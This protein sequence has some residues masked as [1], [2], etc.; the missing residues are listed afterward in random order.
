[1][2]LYKIETRKVPSEYGGKVVW[3]PLAE[4]TN[5]DEAIEYTV[6]KK[7]TGKNEPFAFRCREHCLETGKSKGVPIQE[8][9]KR[10][11]HIS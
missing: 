2:K 1:M 11:A 4:M 10:W 9:S 7:K 5:R 3:S 8:N 6:L